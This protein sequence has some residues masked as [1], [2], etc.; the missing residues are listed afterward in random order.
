[1]SSFLIGLTAFACTFGGAMLGLYLRKVLPEHH[2]RKESEDAVKT[3]AAMIATLAALVLG[4]LVSSAKNSLDTMNSEYA[5]NGAKF[6]MLDR[7]LRFYGPEA[8][9]IREQL[10]AFVQSNVDRMT[11]GVRTKR[12]SGTRQGMDTILDKLR[13][14]TPQNETQ[15]SLQTKAE[16]IATDLMESRVLVMETLQVTL[17]KTLLV[18]LVFWLTI[19]FISIGLFSPYNSTI[20]V[21]LLVCALSVSCAI[22]LIED[23][24]HPFSGLIKVSSAPLIKALERLGR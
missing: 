11:T 21:V 12:T 17:P 9:E 3:G 15:R 8:N 7:T 1:M 22:F 5:Q 19:L 6:I 2:L 20:I 24:S 4:L 18:I 10:K 16:E 23:M 13:A 14:L